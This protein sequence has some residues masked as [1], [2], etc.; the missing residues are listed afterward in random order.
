[1]TDGKL[2]VFE[3]LDGSGKDTQIKLLADSL[4]VDGIT[5]KI[6]RELDVSDLTSELSDL[7]LRRGKNNKLTPASELLLW[8]TV[9]QEAQEEI[10][11]SLR[12]HDIVILNRYLPSFLVMQGYVNKLEHTANAL[13]KHFI[14][15]DTL[16]YLD[17]DPQS[18]HETVKKR[19]NELDDYESKSLEYHRRL[20]QHFQTVIKNCRVKD[21]KLIIDASDSIDSIH[22]KVKTAV[23]RTLIKREESFQ[24]GDIRY[25]DHL[26]TNKQ[27]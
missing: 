7:I 2:I 25:L 1:M 20:H 5:F 3:G 6:V 12:T 8:L 13:T 19:D 22:I 17:K 23:N 24:I 18:V 21:E 10:R 14:P 9:K 15:I 26:I 16:I 11:S 27:M 4:E